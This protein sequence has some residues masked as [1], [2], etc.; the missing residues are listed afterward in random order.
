[1]ENFLTN[2]QEV[3]WTIQVTGPDGEITEENTAISKGTTKFN[4]Q[5]L[6]KKTIFPVGEYQLTIRNVDGNELGPIPF[7]VKAKSAENQAIPFWIKN[8]ADWWA[9][10]SISDTDFVNA[11]QFSCERGYNQSGSEECRTSKGHGS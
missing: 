3:D 6:I 1:M 10:S 4:Y 9:S 2:S 8:T 11:L 7:T 5:Y